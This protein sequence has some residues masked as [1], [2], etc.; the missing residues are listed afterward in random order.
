MRPKAGQAPGQNPQQGP[1]RQGLQEARQHSPTGYREAARIKSGT[2]LRTTWRKARDEL[3]DE[4]KRQGDGENQSCLDLGD[5]GGGKG[6]EA[7]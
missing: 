5:Q 6:A 7:L 2:S 4:T 1:E 3:L